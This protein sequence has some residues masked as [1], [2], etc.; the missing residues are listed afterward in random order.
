M[1]TVNNTIAYLE[2]AERVDVKSFHHKKKSFYNYVVMD[3]QQTD[4]GDHF[5]AYTHT[6]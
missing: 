4:Y 5:A 6:E 2:V 3:V 1:P